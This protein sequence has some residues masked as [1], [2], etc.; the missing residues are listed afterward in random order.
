MIV[1][2]GGGPA[3]LVAAEAVASIE[4]IRFGVLWMVEMLEIE[5]LFS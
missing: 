2:I 5:K 4:L 1:S 3:G